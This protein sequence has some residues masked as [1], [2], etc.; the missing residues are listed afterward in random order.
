MMSCFSCSAE[1]NDLCAESFKCPACCDN[2]CGCDGVED[3]TQAQW[4]NEV[5]RRGMER[6]ERDF[7]SYWS[8][9]TPQNDFERMDVES[10]RRP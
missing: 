6:I 3:A 7:E 8:S 9:D 2:E 4:D 1:T 10:R 5:E